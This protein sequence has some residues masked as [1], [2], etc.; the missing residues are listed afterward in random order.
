M[1]VLQSPASGLRM[2]AP[3]GGITHQSLGQSLGSLGGGAHPLPSSLD[4]MS[5]GVEAHE[6][7][8]L[9]F[10]PLSLVRT[11]LTLFA[12]ETHPRPRQ[13]ILLL[14]PLTHCTIP[15]LHPLATSVSH[16]LPHSTAHAIPNMP[17]APPTHNHTAPPPAKPL[18]HLPAP[19]GPESE[20]LDA[21][22]NMSFLTL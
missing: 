7:D 19:Q 13:R 9:M 11:L 5:P 3:F 17:F 21:S 14:L 20:F 18:T 4:A 16:L 15:S 10:G 12:T 22:D 8:D 6:D 2:S 1:S